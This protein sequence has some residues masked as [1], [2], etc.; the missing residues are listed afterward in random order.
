MLYILPCCLQ[1]HLVVLTA[2]SFPVLLI[3]EVRAW[4]LRV[5]LGPCFLFSF[6]YFASDAPKAPANTSCTITA[7]PGGGRVMGGHAG[8]SWGR[9]ARRALER[10]WVPSR[11]TNPSSASLPSS[12]R[13]LGTGRARCGVP[14]PSRARGAAGSPSACRG[15]SGS[16]PRGAIYQGAGLPPRPLLGRWCPKLLPPGK[17]ILH[18]RSSVGTSGQPRC[19]RGKGVARP[20]AREGG[21]SLLPAVTLPSLR[22]VSFTK[23]L[24]FLQHWL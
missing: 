4:L 14:E 1:H 12:E 15:W 21:W 23:P 5:H 17:F 11:V 16:R 20:A 7:A 18:R 3:R 10:R 6:L 2:L 13:Q 22:Y 19:L 8:A 24:G 9:E